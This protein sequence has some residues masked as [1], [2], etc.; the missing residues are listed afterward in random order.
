MS[1]V[2]FDVGRAEGAEE[3]GFIIRNIWLRTVR[4]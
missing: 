1:F 4:D 3:V 2:D